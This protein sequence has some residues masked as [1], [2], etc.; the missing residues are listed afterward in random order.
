MNIQFIE[1]NKIDDFVIALNTVAKDA[2]SILILSCDENNYDVVKMDSI[3]TACA[4][5]IIGGIFPQIIYQNM[6][7]KM[8]TI[9][10]SLDDILDVNLIQNISDSSNQGLEDVI[11]DK[12]GELDDNIKTMFIFVDGLSKNINALILGLFE[13]FGLSLNYV[14][15]GAG[16]LTFEQ[17]PC[18]FTNQGLIQD[19]AILA[20]SKLESSIGVKHGWTPVS[21][22]MKV[23][24]SEA[25][26]IKEIDYKPAFEVYKDIVQNIS[27][28]T[29]NSNNFFDIAK[30][31]PLGINKLSGDMVVRDPILL[32]KDNNLV[33][34]GD[35]ATNS[36][37]SILTGSDESLI[38]AVFEAKGE[39][40][41]NDM[42]TFTLFIDCI[43][44]VLFMDDRFSKELDAVYEENQL[45]I[46]ALTLGE[47]ANNKTHY[48]EFYNK[49]A[50]IAKIQKN[51]I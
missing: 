41:L 51:S 22:P 35:I 47:I 49:T 40:T 46:G 21:E 26:V 37:I 9:I 38:N 16:S 19:S 30:A 43:S 20:T 39:T 36:F 17:K 3:L 8:G 32:D 44:R 31:Y 1:N 24:S 5:P 4:V 34:V 48:L 11:E 12:V 2:K 23:T 27:Q 18:I 45:L 13:N 10:V 28:Q 14:G 33:C 15:G 29:F 25:N 50:V 6:N 7:Y 42:D